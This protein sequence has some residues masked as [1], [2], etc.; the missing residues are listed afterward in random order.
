MVRTT[1]EN[2]L[3]GIEQDHQS[4]S[5][6]LQSYLTSQKFPVPFRHED[7]GSIFLRNLVSTV[8]QTQKNNINITNLKKQSPARSFVILTH[9]FASDLLLAL[10][11]EEIRTSETSVNFNQT[12][13][14]NIPETVILNF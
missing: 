13:R 2:T 6:F 3:T 1:D 12:T 9:F 8:L 5:Q 10:M 11:M 14:R 7:G 4:Q